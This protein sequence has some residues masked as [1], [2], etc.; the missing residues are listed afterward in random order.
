[1]GVAL[2]ILLK[3]FRCLFFW[4]TYF[5]VVLLT[6]CLSFIAFSLAMCQLE[7]CTV[8]EVCSLMNKPD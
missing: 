7:V 2:V 6:V 4:N 1:M 5:C 8:Q 3:Y